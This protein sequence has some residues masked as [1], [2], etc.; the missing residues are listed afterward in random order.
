MDNCFEVKKIAYEITT[1]LKYFEKER[2][3]FES[4]SLTVLPEVEQSNNEI[5]TALKYFEKEKFGFESRTL[6][7]LPEVEQSNNEI[8]IPIITK[9][10][11]Q[12]KISV[13][14]NETV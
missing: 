11:K 9:N 4:C 2:T 12:I 7:I 3:G 8:I 10:N 6:T 1:A 13:S 5:I 14:V